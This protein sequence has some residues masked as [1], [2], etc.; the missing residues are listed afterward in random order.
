M[1]RLG[2][3]AWLTWSV[4][5]CAYAVALFHRTSLD[6]ASI[7]AEHRLNIG[8]QALASFAFVQLGVY[9]VMQI[10]SGVLA[11]RVGPRR[12][13]S[14]GLVVMAA[15]GVLF[16][17]A[18]APG[19]ALVARALVGLGDACIFLNVLRLAQNWF[20]ARR[21]ALMAA[22]TGL[23]GGVG[24]LVSAAPL[25]LALSGIGW[26]PTFVGAGLFTA[27]LGVIAWLV[28]RDG[29][30]GRHPNAPARPVAAF[31]PATP[32]APGPRA[33]GAT[34]RQRGLPPAQVSDPPSGPRA[35]LVGA[36]G[37]R[38]TRVAMWAAFALNAPLMV[39]ATLW[40]YPWLVEGQGVSAQEATLLMSGVVVANLALA[41]LMGWLAGRFPQRKAALVVGTGSLV[42]A[43]WCMALI[44]PGGRLPAVA[45]GAVLLVTALAG[46]GALVAFDIARAANPAGRG[47]A[48]SGLVNT[49]G[50]GAATAASF[51]AGVI[52]QHLGTGPGAFRVAFAPMV[53]AMALGVA[54]CAV[55]QHRP[56]RPGPP[57]GVAAAP[58]RASGAWAGGLAAS[59]RPA[60]VAVTV[61]ACHSPVG[62]GAG[63]ASGDE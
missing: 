55:V 57:A 52:L 45:L 44:W 47:G 41:P 60:V 56:K 34:S 14:A 1:K 31:V 33:A 22:M 40:G 2:R 51:V 6:V 8:A 21:Y 46:A 29:P 54:A 39:L 16:G 30:G 62:A 27:A 9:L 38:G 5:A 7:P 53:G 17:L 15:G 43:V 61:D 4:G 24:Q 35:A 12:M 19:A 18:T 25:R 48:A 11:D 10:P 23:A 20:P 59:P 28:V 37:E 58:R 50:F 32:S 63:E 13:L 42:V 3:R 26:E 36:L 49:A